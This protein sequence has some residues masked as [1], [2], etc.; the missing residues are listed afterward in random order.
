LRY[1]E[2]HQKHEKKRLVSWLATNPVG[3]QEANIKRLK[4]LVV[5]NLKSRSKVNQ[6]DN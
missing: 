6:I 1:F 3:V 5:N 2:L 4:Y